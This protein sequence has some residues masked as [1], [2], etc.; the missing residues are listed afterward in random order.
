[1]E[2]PI[3]IASGPVIVENG[4]VLLEKSGEDDFWKFIGGKMLEGEKTLEE[5]AIRRSKE[6]MG[7]DVVLKRPL[8][9]LYY[10][11]PDKKVVL[12]H[13]LAERKGEVRPGSN[14]KDWGWFDID[15]L[16]EDCAPNI[17]PIIGD[18]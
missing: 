2:K 14:V 4:K 12:V 3:I 18:L 10:E 1:M 6:S 16:P 11:F 13:W 7:L 8:K 9:T 17:K 15:N 5:T